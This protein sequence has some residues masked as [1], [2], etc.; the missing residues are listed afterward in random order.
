MTH[1]ADT[2]KVVLRP[3]GRIHDAF[4]GAP[5]TVCGQ[6]FKREASAREAHRFG[7]CKRCNSFRS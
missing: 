3:N 1:A 2:I 4:R 6:R 5:V 7:S